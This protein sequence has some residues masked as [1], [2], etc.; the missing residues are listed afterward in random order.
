MIHL[1]LIHTAVC[2]CCGRRV[3]WF[4]R[5]RRWLSLTAARLPGSPTRR[6][7]HCPDSV[8][9]LHD[10]TADLAARILGRVYDGGAR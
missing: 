4:S 3:V 7:T 5:R 10:P 2:D 8:T 6:R 1:P 9:G